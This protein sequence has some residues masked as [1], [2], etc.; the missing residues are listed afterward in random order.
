M[1]AL[2]IEEAIEAA[3]VGRSQVRQDEL[4]SS[5]ARLSLGLCCGLHAHPHMVHTTSM[6]HAVLVPYA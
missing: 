5:A 4:M 6:W 3:G 2:P 1:D